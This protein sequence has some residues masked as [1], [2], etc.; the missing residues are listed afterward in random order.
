MFSRVARSWSFV[1]V[2]QGPEVTHKGTRPQR[3]QVSGDP[4]WARRGW[5]EGNWLPNP[6]QTLS[7]S[8][9][10]R[11][12]RSPRRKLDSIPSPLP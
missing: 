5:A 4:A 3:P 1:Q 10:P 7:P 11:P 8:P 9:E 6:T 2:G 12:Y